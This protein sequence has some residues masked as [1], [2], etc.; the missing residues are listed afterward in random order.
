MSLH[1]LLEGAAQCSPGGAAISRTGRQVTWR[2]LRE[3]VAR[4]ASLLRAG[5]ARCD[6]IAVM[7]ANV[8]EHLEADFAVLWAGLV[9]V[10]I[11]TRLS[12]DEQQY[13][14]AHCECRQLLY[15]ERNAARAQQLSQRLPA[16]PTRRLLAFEG[17]G[18]AADSVAVQAPMPFEPCAPQSAAA[19]FYTGGTTGRPKGAELSH[20]ALLLQG[21]SA[22]DNY[23]FDEATVFM[24]TA[25]MFHLA[26]FA[27]SLGATAA[28]AK[29][30]FLPE[31]TAVG[32]L[33]TVDREGADTVIV[34]P[35]MIP[36][37]LDAAAERPGVLAKLRNILYGAAPIQEPTLLRLLR[38]A[39]GVGL[40]QV[41]GQTELGGG[42][43][44]LLPRQH[45]LDGPE[46]GHLSSAG[47]PIPAFAMR[48]VD[49]QGRV[50]PPGE[51][52]EIQVSG[53]GLMTSYWKDPQGTAAAIEHGWLKTGDLGKMDEDGFVSI[54]GRLK[55]MIITGGE[56]VFAGEVESALMFHA[57]VEA[58]AVIGVPD[59]KWGESVHAEVVLKTGRHATGEELI[60][61]CRARI[62]HYK[63][64]RS[65]SVRQDPLPLSGV[66][67]VRKVELRQAWLD[68]HNQQEQK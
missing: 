44:A 1:Q 2:Q 45:V 17:W 47:R 18:E 22:K 35:T 42:C 58:A 36:P 60:E 19:I 41:Y 4:H 30:C 25:P 56:N 29:H 53:P 23:R 15:D 52:G 6:R 68:R 62:A 8:P 16:L 57:A 31:F 21:L 54:V 63:C 40:Y 34:V 67:K 26:D 64:P 49:E 12:A 59:A 3:R 38:E 20:Q 37:L 65:V 43:T 13:I 32:L 5:A 24:H 55:D 51:A 46:A 48:I 27:A 9:L 50:C 28:R 61:H 7:A 14:V 11:N 33:D 66:G 10:P 39:P